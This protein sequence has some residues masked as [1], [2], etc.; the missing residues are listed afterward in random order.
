MPTKY[1]IPHD[2]LKRLE[3]TKIRQYCRTNRLEP[4]YD[5][6]LMMART[7]EVPSLGQMPVSDLNRLSRDDRKRLSGYGSIE[8]IGVNNFLTYNVPV[9]R[10]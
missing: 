8:I 2:Y 3:S 7:L 5:N 4:M 9:A 1:Q 6:F 10:H